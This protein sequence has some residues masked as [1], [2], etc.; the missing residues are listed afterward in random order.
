MES[1]FSG[2]AGEWR[3][4]R[5]E[6]SRGRGE[7]GRGR[8]G[9]GGRE[10]GREGGRGREGGK[11]GEGRRGREGGWGEQQAII[12]LLDITNQSRLTFAGLHSTVVPLRA[13]RVS[14]DF[15]TQL[16]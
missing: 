7:E 15:C 13:L 16:Q 3:R 2:S 1:L 9:Q 8:E 12:Y 10:G 11:E 6:A 4:D 5:R 14:E